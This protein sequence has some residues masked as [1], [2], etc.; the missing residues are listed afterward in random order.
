[1]SLRYSNGNGQKP[2]AVLVWKSD[3]EDGDVVESSPY[4][5]MY[6]WPNT[7]D[8]NPGLY[9]VPASMNKNQYETV[10]DCKTVEQVTE[11]PSAMLPLYEGV[12][13]GGSSA[14]SSLFYRYVPSKVRT[15]L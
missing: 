13:Y 10:E 1:M 15:L 12:G 11:N 2:A 7:N 8:I 6:A 5:N 4:A 9:E 14:T 3:V